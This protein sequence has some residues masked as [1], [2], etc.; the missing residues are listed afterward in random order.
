MEALLDA[1]R[2]QSF[3]PRPTSMASTTARQ[4]SVTRSTAAMKARTTSAIRAPW[5]R[6]GRLRPLASALP[7]D[8][9]DGVREHAHR[10]DV[11]CR[12]DEAVQFVLGIAVGSIEAPAEGSEAFFRTR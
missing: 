10:L 4:A 7:L 2:K 8:R 9:R 1:D 6:Y 5:P 12:L 3:N 11:D